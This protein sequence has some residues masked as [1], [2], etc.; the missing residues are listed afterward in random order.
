MPLLRLYINAV[1]YCEELP[2]LGEARVVLAGAFHAHA[3]PNPRRHAIGEIINRQS[4][5][6][7]V[8]LRHLRVFGIMRRSAAQMRRQ[9]RPR[10]LVIAV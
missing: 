5:P 4:F 6:L 10:N 3:V 9:W 2:I 1:V 7:S 8:C